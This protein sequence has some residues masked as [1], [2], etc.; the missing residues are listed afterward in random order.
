MMSDDVYDYVMDRV[1]TVRNF[2]VL[3]SE[4]QRVLKLRFE[5]SEGVITHRPSRV[6][7][8]VA[9]VMGYR[10]RTQNRESLQIEQLPPFFFGA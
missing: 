10:V 5:T 1:V 4:N 8:S 9:Q 7:E 6:V 3:L 2:E